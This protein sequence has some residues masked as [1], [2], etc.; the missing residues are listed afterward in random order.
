MLGVRLEK[1]LEKRLEALSKRTNR[2]KSDL[3]KEAL[4]RYLEE[5][6]QLAIQKQETLER[7]ENYLIHQQRITNSQVMDW[8]GSWGE[9]WEK[10]PPR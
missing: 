6:E 8:L 2:S 10:T 5:Q 9:E 7:W 4:V 3:A 1:K